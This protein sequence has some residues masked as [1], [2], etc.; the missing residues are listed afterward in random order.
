MF[1]NS[2]QY[3]VSDPSKDCRRLENVKSLL[4]KIWYVYRKKFKR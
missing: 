1:T 3:R 2:K 4:W